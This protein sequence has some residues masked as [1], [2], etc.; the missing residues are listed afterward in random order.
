MAIRYPIVPNNIIVHLG[1]PSANAR[2]ITIPFTEYISN[3]ASS[4]IYPTWPKNALIANIYTIISFAMNRIYN[5]WYRSKGYNFDITSLP[6]YDQKYT[7]GRSVY[8]NIENIVEDIFNNYVVKNGQVQPYFTRYCDGR[9]TTCDGLSQ[10][11]SVSLANQGKSPLEILKYYYGNDISIFE[12][13]LVGD[14]TIGYPGYEI[15]IGSAG[16][17]VLAIQ[18]DLRRIRKNYPAIPEINNTL[19][20]Y[21]EDTVKAVKKFQEIFD[22]PQTGV[23]NKATWYKI[24]YIY[25]SVKK[26]SDLYSEG[27]TEDEVTFLYTDQLKYGDTGI[28]V[29]YVHYYLDAIAFLDNDIPRLPTNSIYN[30]NTITMVKA[31]QEKY[32]LPVTG[33]FTYSDWQVLKNAYN[34][35]LK[36][37]PVEYANDFYP[38]YFL[39]LGATGNDVKRLQR[40]LLAICKYDKSIPGVRVNGVFDELTEKSIKKIQKD[41]GFDING[42]VGPLLWRKLVELSKR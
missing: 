41:Y 5:E 26:L 23:V 34:K 21:D 9:I 33:I 15:G 3:V 22:L 24:K 19:G 17:Q 10:W 7:E 31:F 6:S 35:I 1:E 16:N 20:I 36:S 32:N 2:D 30:N 29:E 14:N 4:E 11:G 39:S 12:N 37:I 13:A 25:T 28:E 27:L 40:F 8:E 18:R 42:I 38:D